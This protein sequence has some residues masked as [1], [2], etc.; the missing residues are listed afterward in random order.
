MGI[1][2]Q[3]FCDDNGIITVTEGRNVGLGWIHVPC[4]F[5]FDPSFHL[6]F[7]T[8]Y[9]T[10]KC[11]RCGK[12]Q[13]KKV[14][15]RLTRNQTWSEIYQKYYN[16]NGNSVRTKKK[17][18]AVCNVKFPEKFVRMRSE[19]K[20]YLHQRKYKTRILEDKYHLYGTSKYGKWKNR[21]II[22]VYYD[23]R[24]VSFTARDITDRSEIRYKNCPKEFEGRSLKE[25]LYG[26]EHCTK[27]QIIVVEGPTDVW[28]LGDNAVGL[29]G[30]E[31]TK[32]QVQLLSAYSKVFIML[33]PDASKKAEQ[34][35]SDL[36]LLTDVEI[37]DLHCDP[38]D[39]TNAEALEIKRDL[40]GL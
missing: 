2:F 9:N 36:A 38:G 39:L 25:C 16:F 37:I 13:P 18:K 24:P 20:K 5:C 30:I 22:P 14:L 31:Y 3:Q 11:W 32:A 26:Q 7:S 6:G 4:P 10:F 40:I 1:E 19:H 23:C 8:E 28:R 35:A 12:H 27:D 21:I 17:R 34:L 29:F 33:D 15:L